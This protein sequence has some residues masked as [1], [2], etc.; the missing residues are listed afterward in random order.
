[1]I[2]YEHYYRCLYRANSVHLS[3]HASMDEPMQT[4]ALKK[5]SNVLIIHLTTTIPY[6]NDNMYDDTDQ[7]LLITPKQLTSLVITPKQL[8]SKLLPVNIET[9]SVLNFTHDRR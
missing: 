9:L 4:Y 5:K 6:F 1:M 8:T 3:V 7:P 2:I